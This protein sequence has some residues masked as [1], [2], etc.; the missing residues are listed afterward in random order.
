[1]TE[2]CGQNLDDFVE[3]KTIL[4]RS[5]RK[6]A[7]S[8]HESFGV[9]ILCSCFITVLKKEYIKP[10]VDVILDIVNVE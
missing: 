4:A 7:F 1:M 2:L 10:N 6:G 9:S 5:K 8:R 3:I